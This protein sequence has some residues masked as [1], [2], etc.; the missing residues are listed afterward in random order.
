[1]GLAV[2]CVL[3]GCASFSLSARGPV[4]LPAMTLAQADL[5]GCGKA[6]VSHLNGQPFSALADYR[7]KG[8]LRVL[9]PGQG[10]TEDL[11]PTRLNAQ[12]DDKGVIM[13]LFCG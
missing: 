10:V 6:E 1:M 11:M 9:R 8:Q 2:C 5:G 12:V 3:A 13:H 7:L 4:I